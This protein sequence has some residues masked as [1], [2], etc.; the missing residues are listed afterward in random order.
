MKNK[1]IIGGDLVPTESN[2]ELFEDGDAKELIGEELLEKFNGAEFTIFNLEGPLTDKQHP[3]AKCGPNLIASTATINGLKAINPHFFGLANNHILDQGVEGLE[4]TA[5]ALGAAG[6]EYAG[7]GKN[8][9]E[10]SKPF[11]KEIGGKR[12]GIYCCCEHEFSI[13]TNS[14]PGANPFD[15]LES[16]D[17]IEKLKEKA[18][19]VIV[20]YHGGKEHYRYPS[21]H[22]QKVC[23]K[24]I[25]KGA[26]LVVCQHSHCIGCEEK[27][28]SGTIVYGQGNFLFDDNDN[29]FGETGLLVAINDAF[30][31]SYIPTIKTGNGV[32]LACEEK[33]KKILDE[34]YTR[35]QEIQN[36]GFVEKMYSGF[37]DSYLDSYLKALSGKKS[38]AFRAFNKLTNGRMLKWMIKKKYPQVNKVQ[39]INYVECEAHRELMLLALANVTQQEN[40]S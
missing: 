36:P 12:I 20:L 40:R 27:Y 8:L 23:R 31:I 11:I 2:C 9:G 26:D 18:D 33:S 13:A 3:I 19:Y 24:L 6:I 21:P 16:L 7:I 38:F 25:D 39:I 30:E 35:S 1:I 10:A 15:P 17:H 34:F 37:A 4:S 28:K 29:E 14:S 5:K 32:R 22:L